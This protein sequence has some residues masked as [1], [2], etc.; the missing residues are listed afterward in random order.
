MVPPPSRPS[1]S[2][3]CALWL[4]LAGVFGLLR[5]LVQQRPDLSVESGLGCKS[6]A[7]ARGRHQR[8]LPPQR[9]THTSDNFIH[10][11]LKCLHRNSRDSSGHANRLVGA[12]RSHRRRRNPANLAVRYVCRKIDGKVGNGDA[13]L[14][15][16]IMNCFVKL[17]RVWAKEELPPIVPEQSRVEEGKE[18]GTHAPPPVSWPSSGRQNNFLD[19]L[20]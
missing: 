2:T 17:R 8:L 14:V 12:D 18:I 3:K 1:R 9:Q 7:S 20:L 5:D 10:I 13:G 6:V 16:V 4:A 11:G 19:D 15:S